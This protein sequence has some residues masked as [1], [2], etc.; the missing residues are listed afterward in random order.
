MHRMYCIFKHLELHQ[1]YCSCYT[2][3]YVPTSPNNPRMFVPNGTPKKV[4]PHSMAAAAQ[5]ARSG[6]E[7]ENTAH[8]RAKQI[9][10]FVEKMNPIPDYH[11]TSES[12]DSLRVAFLQIFHLRI[13][14]TTMSSICEF[15]NVK[16]TN[17][18][19]L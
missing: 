7:L 9:A 14:N 2:S 8:G 15:K 13:F 16:A 18:E 11:S 12:I 3:L 4:V 10:N 6:K 1:N 19:K 17:I 5:K